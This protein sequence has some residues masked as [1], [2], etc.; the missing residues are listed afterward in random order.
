MYKLDTINNN[1]LWN[2]MESTYLGQGNIKLQ[3]DKL[4]NLESQKN[5]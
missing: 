1:D 2:K 3:V 4:S 5:Y